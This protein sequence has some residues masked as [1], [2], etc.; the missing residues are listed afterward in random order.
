MVKKKTEDITPKIT[1]QNLKL[2]QH[3]IIGRPRI[4]LD[5]D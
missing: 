5:N 2:S 4:Q 1:S 3:Q